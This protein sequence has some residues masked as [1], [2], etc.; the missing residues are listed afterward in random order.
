MAPLTYTTYQKRHRHQCM[1][2]FEQ[3][4]PHFFAV[5]ERADY[6]QFLDSAPEN[7]WLVRQSDDFIACYGLTIQGLDATI[8]WIMVDPAVHR[9][10]IGSAMIARAFSIFTEHSVTHLKVATS[11]HAVGFFA[12]FGLTERS[13]T[14][15]GW[16]LGMHRID[17]ELGF[18]ACC[19]GFSQR[20][21]EG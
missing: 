8:D 21:V 1:A 14:M 20:G 18:R 7:Y 2:L 10:G 15:N 12:R 3:N 11:Q 6:E 19:Q 9:G 5:E 16:G 17:M 4:C 13:R